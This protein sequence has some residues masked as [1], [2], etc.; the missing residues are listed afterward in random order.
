MDRGAATLLPQWRQ[1]P[2]PTN[3]T[4]SPSDISPPGTSRASAIALIDEGN[5]LEEQGRTAEAMARYDAAV[6]AD[7]GCA[8]AHLNDLPEGR[9]GGRYDRP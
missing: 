3:P 9:E 1:T 6:Q 8:R 4:G 5:A 7:P 2:A